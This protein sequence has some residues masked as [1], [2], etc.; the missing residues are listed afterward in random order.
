MRLGRLCH[1][2]V[3]CSWV[4]F[5][6]GCAT[7]DLSP[8][9]HSVRHIRG[10]DRTAVLD[11]ARSALSGLGYPIDRVD[12]VAGVVTSQPVPTKSL[13]EPV[14]PRGTR[15]SSRSDVRQIAEVR[16]TYAGDDVKVYCRVLL[17]EQTTRVHQIFAQD[18]GISDMPDATPIDRDAG[19]TEQ[20]NIVWQNVSRD[21]TAERAILRAILEQTGDT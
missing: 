18:R 16:V 7:R 10:G 13:R 6:F 4:V 21:K 5:S 2:A 19:T 11:A 9:S 20:Q 14:H 3:V 8:L 12:Q 15:I 1:F 17:Q